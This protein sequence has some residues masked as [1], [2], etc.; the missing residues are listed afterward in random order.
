MIVSE[1][2]VAGG[3]SR[4]TAVVKTVTEC[5]GSEVTGFRSS[6]HWIQHGRGRF[7]M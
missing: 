7:G 5:H 2:A 6:S 3:N 1:V 4:L